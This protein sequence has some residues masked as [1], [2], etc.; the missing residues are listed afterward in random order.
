MDDSDIYRSRIK[1]LCAYAVDDGYSLRPESEQG[2]WNFFGA[3][4]S[5]R[6]F[7][8]VLIDNG[9]LRAVWQDEE[10]THVGLQ[11]LGD[12]IVQFVL[13]KRRCASRPVSRVVG[14]DTVAGF[15]S[16]IRAFELQSLLYE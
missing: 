16:Q 4:P 3:G 13:F 5:L 9:N 6:R 8:L 11:F 1:E 12:D 15:E 2:F 14:R 7:E 10:E